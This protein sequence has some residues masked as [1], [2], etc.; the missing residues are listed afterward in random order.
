MAAQSPPSLFRV[1]RHRLPT[2]QPRP[3]SPRAILDSAAVGPF[4][5]GISSGRWRRS[6]PGTLL[7]EPWGRPSASLRP[8]QNGAQLHHFL[9]LVRG[10]PEQRDR[11]KAY[12]EPKGCPEKT[13][14]RIPF[15]R[16]TMSNLLRMI[17]S[18]FLSPIRFSSSSFF[19][20]LGF[21]P[22]PRSGAPVPDHHLIRTPQIGVWQGEQVD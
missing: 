4:S 7:R 13:L 9:E 22:G 3:P 5:T 20:P 21:S 2:W 17:A 18:R 15:T 1:L 10:G 6:R 12:K 14:T 16:S 8:R 11:R 19:L